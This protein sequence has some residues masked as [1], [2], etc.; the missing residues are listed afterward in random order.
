MSFAP[1][2]LVTFCQKDT[3]QWRYSSLFKDIPPWAHDIK[4]DRDGHGLSNL[5]QVL[6]FN[7]YNGEQS[8]LQLIEAISPQRALVKAM[9]VTPEKEADHMEKELELKETP[10]NFLPVGW[11][12][13]VVDNE[14]TSYII[15]LAPQES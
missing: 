14:E 9:D 6:T 3:P 2:E 5:Y 4:K 15:T 8:E 10:V 13:W 1:D 11:R 7:R 12:Q